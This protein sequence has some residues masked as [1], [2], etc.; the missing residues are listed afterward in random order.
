MR[1]RIF[2]ADNK[3]F[4]FMG[5]V[6]DLIILNV[7]FVVCSLPVFTIGASATAMYYVALKMIK[8]EESYI[9]RSFF[10]SFK[11]NFKQATLIWLVLLA[12]A[13]LLWLD[14]SIVSQ[15]E[16]VG[17]LQFISIGLYFVLLLWGMIFV[18]VFPLLAKFD[19]TVKN[20]FKNALKMAICHFPWTVLLLLITCVPMFFTLNYG[21][22]LMIGMFVWPVIGF[23]L[24]AFI[25]SLILTRIFSRYIPK[26]EEEEEWSLNIDE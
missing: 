25:N 13:A 8:N 26:E 12:A 6:S 23:A 19:N 22:V 5:K 18:Y 14:F 7:I 2:N 4:H 9:S 3:F 21:F 15:A 17:L 11:Q 24:T 10:H 1:E 20:T 16:A